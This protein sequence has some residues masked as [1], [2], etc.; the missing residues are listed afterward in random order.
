MSVQDI[1]FDFEI[2]TKT[3]EFTHTRTRVLGKGEKGW[4]TNP[5]KCLSQSIL[6]Q[7]SRAALC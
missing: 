2:K 6:G 5:L 4:E 1:D 7:K 3:Q